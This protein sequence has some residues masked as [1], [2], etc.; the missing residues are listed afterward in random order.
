MQIEA[1][2]L[3]LSTQVRGMQHHGTTGV[4]CSYLGNIKTELQRHVVGIKHKLLVCVLIPLVNHSEADTI[5]SNVYCTLLQWVHLHSYMRVRCQ[6]PLPI[7]A[8]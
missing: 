3:S 1:L 4:L 6:E 7:M 2:S 8:R 5:R